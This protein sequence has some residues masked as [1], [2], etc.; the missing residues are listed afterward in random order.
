MTMSQFSRLVRRVMDTLPAEFAPFLDNLVVDV[1]RE[2]SVEL[3][4]RAGF[5]EEEI[6]DGESLLGLF[7]P[8]ELSSPWGGDAIDTHDM[9]HRLWIFRDPH[10]EEFP[11]PKRMAI[12][13]RKTVIHELAHH[14][15]FSERDL[16][17]FD[18]N[19]DPF[20]DDFPYADP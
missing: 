15:G 1:D 7:D 17:K 18:A 3:L 9:G 16:E 19:P 8:L 12:E 5:T 14:F 6:D 13:V 11:D 20:G 10:Q 2:P 4:R